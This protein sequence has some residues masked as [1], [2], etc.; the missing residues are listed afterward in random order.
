MIA[1]LALCALP[2]FGHIPHH[3]ID[4]LAIPADL[5]PS[6]TWYAVHTPYGVSNLMA[7]EG[8]AHTGWGAVGG[9]P[10]AD[11]I[12]DGA[13]LDDGTLVLLSEDHLWWSADGAT[14]QSGPPPLGATTVLGGAE[15]WVAGS[16][17]VWRGLPDQGL[18]PSLPDAD[19]IHLSQGPAGLLAVVAGGASLYLF[20]GSAW[21]E[22]EGPGSSVLSGVY[23]TDATYVGD[24]AGDV[25]RRDG[26]AWVA[27]GELPDDDSGME[28]YPHV[29]HM[30][31]DG[32]R[33]LAVPAWKG[34]FASDDG[35]A[36]WQDRA[37]PLAV[38]FSQTDIGSSFTT[39][40]ADGDRWAIAG[41]DSIGVSDDAGQS[42]TQAFIMP[43]DITRGLEHSP[44]YASDGYAYLGANGAGIMRS[45]DGYH[46]ESL[47]GGMKFPN[48]QQVLFPAWATDD[49]TLY[50]ISNHVFW[51]SDDG[52]LSWYE[53]ENPH[54]YVFALS[55]LRDP[56]RIWVFGR[57]TGGAQSTQL[58]QSL[59]D[60]RTW[61]NIPGLDLALGGSTPA[62]AT[63]TGGGEVC[64]SA[65]NP[66][67]V[68]CSSEGQSAWTASYGA[69]S[70]RITPIFAWPPEA[71]ARVVFADGLGVHV[72]DD[73]GQ[74]WTTAQSMTDDTVYT[75]T[76]ADDGTL[77]LATTSANLL[78]S[79]DGGTSWD[80]LGL[81]FTA[82]VFVLDPRPDFDVTAELLVGGHDGTFL[83]TDALGTAPRSDRWG[84]YNLVDN[85]STYIH[86]HDEPSMEICGDCV[87][88]QK[89]P[90]APGTEA[91]LGLRGDVV[92]VIGTSDGASELR[93]EIDGA[94]AGLLGDVA[95]DTPTVLAEVS[96]LG[97][98]YHQVVLTGMTGSGFALD[99]FES[100]EGA[101]VLGGGPDDTGHETDE[102]ETDE[103]ETDEPETDTPVD[104]GDT[105][106]TFRECFCGS[107]GLAGGL[108]WLLGGTAV[109]LRRRRAVS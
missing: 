74:S 15:L 81:R 44:T 68:V 45:S 103:P 47:A 109:A 79:T 19:V 108:L 26:E 69:E 102:P 88:S 32:S 91:Y 28:W 41:W 17:G 62:Y 78:R 89:Q 106:G 50:G 34:P 1:L 36:T 43:P 85:S 86:W 67:T 39:M 23:D 37:S 56:D 71:P 2:A 16:H 30:A 73:D 59:D 38:Q 84:A 70:E 92:R 20:D 107:T 21:S 82:Q 35:C 33:V 104:T 87:M 83:V 53:Q 96:G 25:W 4:A 5:S 49:Q 3:T 29:T 27:C 63:T 46:F 93:L 54:S 11:V 72:S 58:S 13:L 61:S 24:T 80:D 51:R 77:F 14:W 66:I 105:G 31:A 90:F 40:L 48:I 42:W 9:E 99:C 10:M 60:G 98:G 6:E 94:T 64:V 57:S 22:L 101:L 52:G 100:G 12:V 76:M 8:G 65:S 97:P 75:M 18:E 7:S 55:T 95:A